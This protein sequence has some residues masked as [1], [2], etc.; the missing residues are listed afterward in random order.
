LDKVAA[1][2][3][4][5]YIMKSKQSAVNAAK[6]EFFENLDLAKQAGIGGELEDAVLEGLPKYQ[7]EKRARL[8]AEQRAE[9]LAEALRKA[10]IDPDS[11]K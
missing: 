8:R 3:Y 10:G 4:E 5:E 2:N 6:K 11:V 9:R 1:I 7:K